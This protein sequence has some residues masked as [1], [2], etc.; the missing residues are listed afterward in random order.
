MNIEKMGKIKKIFTRTIQ[1]FPAF[2]LLLLIFVPIAVAESKP[3]EIDHAEKTQTQPADTFEKNP[4][5]HDPQVQREKIASST[6]DF[7]MNSSPISKASMTTLPSP[8]ISDSGN[9]VLKSAIQAP[10]PAPIPDKPP[11]PE[12]TPTPEAFD[13]VSMLVSEQCSPNKDPLAAETSCRR[14][15]SNG[16]YATV[17]TQ[18]SDEGDEFKRQTVIEEYDQEDHLI[19]KKTIRQR[20]DFNYFNEKKVKEKEFFDIIYQPAGKKTTRELMIYQFY[21]DTGKARSL[22][23]TQYKQIGNE[24]KAGLSFYATLN[25]G[26]DGSPERGIAEKWNAG[27]KT[28]SFINWSRISGGYAS[29]DENTWNEW[30]SWIRNVGMQAYLP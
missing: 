8:A 17:L 15:Y 16:H 3:V 25:Y 23:W 21:L 11:V 2:C 9:T 24:P 28:A 6:T 10:S 26:E 27:Q 4:P 5:E 18:R 1:I 19:F 22:S 30:E 7:L 12:L 13:D 29:L 20:I 14:I